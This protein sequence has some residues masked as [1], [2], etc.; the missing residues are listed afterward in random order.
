MDPEPVLQ[1]R[2]ALPAHKQVLLPIPSD[3][4]DVPETKLSGMVLPLTQ[5]QIKAARPREK[6]YKLADGGGLYLE[7]TPAGGRHWP[8]KYRRPNGRENKLCF[9]AFAAVSLADARAKRDSAKK[10]LASGADPARVWADQAREA[11]L[12]ASTP[13]SRWPGTGTGRRPG[14]GSRADSPRGRLRS[15][16]QQ[17]HQS[18]T[19]R[20]RIG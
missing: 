9:G 16:V 20:A 2:T 15:G 14:S 5:P 3:G 8:M 18:T 7:L 10:L 4:S 11:A 12:K 19:C 6:A 17:S 13:L 1:G